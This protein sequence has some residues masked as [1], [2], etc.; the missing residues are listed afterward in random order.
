[1]VFELYPPDENGIWVFRISPE[2]TLKFKETPEGQ[3]ESLIFYQS[4]GEF[5]M[6][7]VAGDLLPTVEDILA[8]RQTESSMA[9][10]EK[11]GDYKITGTIRSL[12]SGVDGTFSI[13]VSG[14]ERYRV[15]SD[16]GRYGYSRTVVNGDRAWVESSFAPFDELHGKLLEQAKLGHPNVEEGD[17]RG[18]YD[19]IQVLR[20]DSLN[21]RKVYVLELR[22]GNLPPETIFVDAMNGDILKSVVVA[23]QEGGIG[24][25]VTTQYE[26]F[27]E[28]HG[29][30]IPFRAISSNEETGRTIIQ[31]ENIEVNLDIDDTF[32]ILTPKKG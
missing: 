24:I 7:R 21:G 13:Y 27:R 11:M 10:I 2:L 16:Y 9:A 6:T 25:S 17:W 22:H 28:I 31:Y 5:P 12:Q 8:L 3:V 26:D 32:F 14:K 15:D 4:G 29:L 30:R 18:F 19:S 20:S 23:L 1:M